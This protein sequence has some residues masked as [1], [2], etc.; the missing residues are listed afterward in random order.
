MPWNVNNLCCVWYR[1][2]KVSR[3]GSW[4]IYH[5]TIFQPHLI[6]NNSV[7]DTGTVGGN[8][9][10]ARIRL[11]M[12]WFLQPYSRSQIIS[13]NLVCEQNLL[14]TDGWFCSP[15]LGNWYFKWGKWK[16]FRDPILRFAHNVWFEIFTFFD[17]NNQFASN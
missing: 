9:L 10:I 14:L 7:S 17:Q 3:P 1:S 6:A 4:W 15:P 11:N 16:V 5:R 2:L 8:N 13:E 12:K